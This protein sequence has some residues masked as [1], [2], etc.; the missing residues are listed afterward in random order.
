MVLTKEPVRVVLNSYRKIQTYYFLFLYAIE[1][2]GG[3]YSPLAPNIPDASLRLRLD[4]NSNEFP[5]SHQSIVCLVIKI[6]C[7]SGWFRKCA[8]NFQRRQY[9]AS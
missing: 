1:S 6:P 8:A 7:T 5:S 2:E 9:T 4:T 3:D